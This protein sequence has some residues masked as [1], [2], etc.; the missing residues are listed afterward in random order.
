MWR[1]PPS[2]PVSGVGGKP[3]YPIGVGW[4][5]YWTVPWERVWV[6]RANTS[7][8]RA[9]PCYQAWTGGVGLAG[10]PNRAGRGIDPPSP[11]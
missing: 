5:A 6:K 1:D 2:S 3:H 4:R 7:E 10:T 8:L 11:P 9:A